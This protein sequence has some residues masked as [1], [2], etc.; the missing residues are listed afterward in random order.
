MAPDHMAHP[1]EYRGD[2]DECFLCQ[3]SRIKIK[4]GANLCPVCDNPTTGEATWFTEW[5][6]EEPA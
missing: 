6:N 5:G 1:I 2:R 4:Y 3:M